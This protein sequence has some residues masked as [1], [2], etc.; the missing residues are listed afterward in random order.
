MVFYFLLHI[1][2]IV[3]MLISI[4]TQLIA[5]HYAT[6]ENHMVIDYINNILN[7]DIYLWHIHG[8]PGSY[9]VKRYT[10]YN[11]LRTKKNPQTPVNSTSRMWLEIS[12]VPKMFTH[13]KGIDGKD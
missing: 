9:G 10:L 11:P 13:R 2:Y 4:T 12:C 1:T 7:I 6:L 3:N 8:D 5:H